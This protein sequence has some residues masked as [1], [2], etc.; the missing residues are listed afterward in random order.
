VPLLKGEG[1]RTER[2]PSATAGKLADCRV[3]KISVSPHP[4]FGKALAL[5]REINSD[6]E[7]VR[8]IKRLPFDSRTVANLA[9]ATVLGDAIDHIIASG[10]KTERRR[11]R[12]IRRMLR[13]G[14]SLTSH[15]QKFVRF[16]ATRASGLTRA[17]TS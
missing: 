14:G 5:A 7:E 17:S 4:E 11:A 13:A 12:L 2:Y 9:W 15:D 6:P 3:A 10:T 8:A 1:R 16:A